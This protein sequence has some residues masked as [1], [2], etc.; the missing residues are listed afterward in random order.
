MN[1][2]CRYFILFIFYSFLG[3]LWEVVDKIVEEKKLVNRGFMVGPIC[4]IYGVGCLLLV[5]L[6]RKY[7]NDFFILFFMAI[8]ICSILEYSTSYLMEKIF[9]ARWWDYSKQKFNI[10]GRICAET[11]IP[12]GLLGTLVVGYVNPFLNNLL[13]NF[14]TN[15]INIIG[16]TLIVIFIIDFIISF[17][18]INKFSKTMVSIE[19]DA[20]EEIS[21][22]V[23]E[24]LINHGYLYKRLLNSFPNVV[25]YREYLLKMKNKINKMIEDEKKKISSLK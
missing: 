11:M 13:L 12:F 19:K 1:F 3:W 9:K 20:T 5:L 21:K 18:V 17:N 15:I 4:P 8:L 2:I 22:L 10:N 16:I 14:N 6:L 24:K 25:N 7:S 23:R